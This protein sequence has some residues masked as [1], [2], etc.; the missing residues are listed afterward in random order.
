MNPPGP[1]IACLAVIDLPLAAWRRA[2][3][4]LQRAPLA[5]SATS[6]LTSRI[7]ACSEEAHALGVRAGMTASQARARAP[8]V[9]L[10]PLDP[11]RLSAARAAL[12]DA[13]F[14]LG[15]EVEPDGDGAL[16]AIGD[17]GRLYPDE[18]A[19][20]TEL[21]RR[22][23]AVGL[24]AR[25]GVAGSKGV[26][27]LAAWSGRRAIEVIAPGDEAAFISPL[28][29][30]ALRPSE[31]ARAALRR[32]GVADCGR[33][34][35]ID[36]KEVALRLGREG[37]TL[38]ALARGRADEPLDSRPPSFELEEGQALDFAIFELEALTFVLSGV[39]SRLLAR[40]ASRHLACGGV[41]LRLRL[42]D[43]GHDLREVGLAAPTREPAPLLAIVRLSVEER[44]PPAAVV[45]VTMIGHAARLKVSQLDLFAPA[46]PAPDRLAT[47][48]ARLQALCGPDAV[49]RVAPLDTHRDEA[50]AILPFAALPIDERRA[51]SCGPPN[52]QLT[53]R[54]FRPPRAVEVLL[55]EG[56]IPRALSGEGLSAQLAIAAGPYRTSGEW[57]SQGGFHSDA[58]DV[59]ASDGALYRLARDGAGHWFLEGYYD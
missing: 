58:W 47:T 31:E 14:A 3:P 16:I 2:D 59:H 10:R 50:F 9:E 27:R 17:L 39:A 38:A 29:I 15:A 1:R 32:W 7:V 54:R 8:E 26:A 44:P 45:A 25:V 36:P 11:A 57:W 12:T 49:G 53:L 48:V 33:L 18:R 46:G 55:G 19:I 30:E 52:I 56:A 4:A 51:G 40:L 23:R 13:A 41:T 20:A 24:E 21:L 5:V 37:A 42:D 22:A 6:A 34:A 28:P 43:G 35:A